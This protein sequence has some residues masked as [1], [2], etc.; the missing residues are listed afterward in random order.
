MCSLLPRLGSRWIIFSSHSSRVLVP[1]PC[2]AY[3]EENRPKCLEKNAADLPSGCFFPSSFGLSLSGLGFQLLMESSLLFQFSSRCDYFLGVL[4]LIY[5]GPLNIFSLYE[6]ICPIANDTL[7]WK[8]PRY[9]ARLLY[10]LNYIGRISPIHLLVVF[11]AHFLGCIL[12]AFFFCAL[13]PAKFAVRFSFLAHDNFLRHLIL[14]YIIPHLC[15]GWQLKCLLLLCTPFSS[16]L[17]RN[18]SV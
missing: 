8:Y 11:P 13:C 10:L 15:L 12:G 6:R 9:E 7:G 16:L 5:L 1:K 2:G 14:S 18:Y 3:S 4:V 17:F